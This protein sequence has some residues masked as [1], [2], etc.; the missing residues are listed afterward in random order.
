MIQHQGRGAREILNTAPP[1]SG[2]NFASTPLSQLSRSLG[3]VHKDEIST[4]Q[5]EIYQPPAARETDSDTSSQK[6]RR[7]HTGPE[8]NAKSKF[9][10][11]RQPSETNSV[12]AASDSIKSQSSSHSRETTSSRGSVASDKSKFSDRTKW[13][14]EQL[15]E[16]SCWICGNQ[17]T[18]LDVRHVI[19]R[20]DPGFHDISSRGIVP[21]SHRGDKANA[22]PLCKRCHDGFDSVRPQVIIL[23]ADLQYFLDV[24]EQ[25]FRE[26][27][28]N[29]QG[30][31]RRRLLPSGDQ[32]RAHL[33]NSRPTC[34]EEK[35]LNNLEDSDLPG[36]LYQAYIREDILGTRQHP[37]PLGKYDEPRIWHGS[38][39]AMSMHFRHWHV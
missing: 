4:L 24:E 37:I 19:A 21:F 39:T 25:D 20:K 36:G 18:N 31:I 22:I 14:V 34:V 16:E 8:T 29:A 6:R 3:V 5:F 27:S 12:S 2:P 28:E 17:R 32:Y 10:R 38:P 33:L 9:R 7:S 23:P 35:Y 15:S 26:R 1:P 30:T 13:D 11:R